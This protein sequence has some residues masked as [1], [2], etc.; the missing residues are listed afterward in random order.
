MY[1]IDR[2]FDYFIPDTFSDDLNGFKLINY[3]GKA[4]LTIAL[5]LMYSAVCFLVFTYYCIIGISLQISGILL[6]IGISYMLALMWLRKS[7]NYQ[8]ATWVI[9]IAYVFAL[10]IVI[11]FHHGSTSP[12]L[13]WFSAG[14]VTVGALHNRKICLIYTL[15]SFVSI[16]LIRS[17]PFTYEP[18]LENDLFTNLLIDA[19]ALSSTLISLW[20]IFEKE[21]F[22]KNELVG[23]EKVKTINLLITSLSDNINNPL[24]VAKGN[25]I[26]FKSTNNTEAKRKIDQ[27]LDQIA[28]V[29][30][31]ISRISDPDEILTEPY[32]EVYSK[33]KLGEDQQFYQ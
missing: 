28:N 16:I 17:L 2:I 6:G 32:R 7:G 5:C 13:I 10:P 19:L 23:I 3:L 12:N 30:T 21:K 8:V 14:I 15:I 20:M 1:K 22:V 29:V 25:L 26:K 31:Q 27:S 11:Y 24:T 9:L 33:L 4:K 18:I